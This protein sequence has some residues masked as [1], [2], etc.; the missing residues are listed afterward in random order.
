MIQ[1]EESLKVEYEK[2]LKILNIDTNPEWKNIIMIGPTYYNGRNTME[3]I[4]INDINDINDIGEEWDM[5]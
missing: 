3:G 4:D 1:I 2:C 5:I